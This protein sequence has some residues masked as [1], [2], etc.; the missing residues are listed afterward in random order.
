MQNNLQKEESVTMKGQHYITICD[1]SS[2]EAQRIE[3]Q[4]E[5][6]GERR[7]QALQMIDCGAILREH[8]EAV[9]KSIHDEYTYLIQKLHA[10]F[11]VREFYKENLTVTAGRSVLAQ[12]L[13]GTTTYTGVINYT[14]LGTGT[15]PAAVSDTQLQTETYRKAL[16]S[17]AYASNVAY[18]E[19]FFTAAEV[20]GTFQEY[21]NFI[22]GSGTVNSGQMFNHFLQAITKTATETLNVQS[23]FTFADA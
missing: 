7:E 14:A 21:G 2:P 6:V 11:K 19:T 22:D 13:A 23:I 12:R 16:S 17:G 15:N 4:I 20:S 9:L 1:V 5:A 10:K 18:I 8:A 3:A